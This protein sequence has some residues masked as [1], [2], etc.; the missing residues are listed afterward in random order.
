MAS[1]ALTAIMSFGGLLR[2]LTRQGLNAVQVVEMLGYFM[3]AMSTYAFP[4]AAL[5]AATL[6]YGR[7]AT[8]NELTAMRASGIS[9]MGI[10]VPGIVLGLIVAGISMA[11]VCFVVPVA[12]MRV[13]RVMYSNVSQWMVTQ[14]E[15]NHELVVQNQSVFASSARILP[16][17]PKQPDETAVLLDSPVI[18]SGEV[19]DR[20]LPDGKL[21]IPQDFYLARQAVVRIGKASED[22]DVQVMIDLQEGTSFPRKPANAVQG[23]VTATRFGPMSM[24]SRVGEKTKFM[25]LKKLHRLSE[26]PGR[27]RRVSQV[28]RDINRRVQARE[29]AKLLAAEF[30]GK[31]SLR[32]E[33]LGGDAWVITRSDL[34]IKVTDETLTV[35]GSEAGAGAVVAGLA[36][37][38]RPV[39]LEQSAGGVATLN[40]QARGAVIKIRADD[41]AQRIYLDLRLDD[42]IMQDGSESYAKPRYT[43]R[44]ISLPMPADIAAISQTTAAAY[45]QQQKILPPD[46][47]G[48]FQR[49]LVATSNEVTGE[50]NS[51]AGFAISSFILVLVGVALGMMFK[52]GHF[53]SA[54]AVSIVPALLCIVLNVTGQHTLE[55]VPRTMLA[56]NWHNPLGIGLTVIWSGNVIVLI[57]AVILLTRLQRQ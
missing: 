50:L 40:G 22:D 48:R 27:A 38:A 36:D 6:V 57:L 8:D 7:L 29:Y 18:I 23:G 10:A 17:D 52:S 24:P 1:G 28:V 30:K 15:R 51:R 39:R 32:L 13:E 3:P 49:E 37:A 47:K 12:I 34:P 42:A 56:A 31:S 44:A 20:P 21:L 55:N 16:A 53:L 19:E 5:F 9:H 4:I 11:M 45:I 2:P 41:V 46:L 33:G 43:P 54:F 14:I 35:G 26:D 25:D